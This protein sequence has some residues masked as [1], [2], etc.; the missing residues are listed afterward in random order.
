[1]NKLVL[2]VAVAAACGTTATAARAQTKPDAVSA[3]APVEARPAADESL[4]QLEKNPADW[5]MP[6]KN[7]AGTR[8]SSLKQINAHNA[9][10]LTMAWTFST[11][12]L[13]GHEAAPL[14]IGDTMYVVTPWP[15]ILYALDLSNDGAIKWVFKPHPSRAAQGVACCDVVNRGVAYA[16]GKIF[17]NTLD[18]HTIA[19]DAKTGKQIWNTKVGDISTGETMTMAPLVVK[20]HVLVGNSGGELGVRGWLKSLDTDTGKVQWTA[21]STGPDKDVLIGKDFDPPYPEDKGRNL[22][23]TSWPNKAAWEIGGGPVWGW[24]TYDPELD[25]IYYGTGNPGPWNSFQRPGLNF[26]TCTL[27]ARDPATGMAKWAVQWNPHDTHDYDGVNESVLF[28]A[29]IDGKER[30]LL[31]HPDRNGYLYVQDRTTGK[32]I[33]A[34]PFMSGINTIERIDLVTG[35]PV[36]NP[37]KVPQLDKTVHDICPAST[38]GK[39]WQPSAYSPLTGLLYIPHNHLCQDEEVSEVSYI[40]GTPFIGAKVAMK[41]APGGWRGAFTAYDPVHA[42]V[43]WSDHENFP[44][45]SGAL[46]TAGGVVFYGTMDRWFKAVDATTGKLLWK[47]RVGSG[48]NGQPIAYRGPDGRE[49]VAILAGVGGWSGAVVAGDLDPRDPYGALGYV[50]ATQDLPDYTAKGG[51]LYVFALPKTGGPP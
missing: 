14:V 12:V 7:Y 4:L 39:D 8:F 9:R 31:A 26:W 10:N 1:M 3:T 33:S 5:P 16:D 21:Y 6:A 17:M 19:V 11:G 23:E 51:T 32:I 15:N 37:A 48:I 42:K 40:E 41:A 2:A 35:A 38:G 50:G 30:Q 13:H 22:G 43:V 29:K 20:N 25:L 45:W 49:Y 34:Q 36:V 24:I 28:N 44:V 27:F 47:F 18:D 46:V